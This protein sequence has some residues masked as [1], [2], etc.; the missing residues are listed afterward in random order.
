MRAL[1][2]TVG[3]DFQIAARGDAFKTFGGAELR[4]ESADPRGV[5]RPIRGF[6][7]GG[8]ESRQ[9]DAP[10]RYIG[11]RKAEAAER[12]LDQD[13]V[14]VGG[15][16]SIALPKSVVI[17]VVALP[18]RAGCV[19]LNAERIHVEIED[20]LA[21][22]KRVEIDGDFVVALDIVAIRHASAEFRFLLLAEEDHV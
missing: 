3:D 2:E 8:N 6:V 16:P 20:V 1:S 21:V 11:A 12:N 19:G 7:D 10:S 13:G 17:V 4:R 18:L 9:A 14:T 15:D 5:I 22:A